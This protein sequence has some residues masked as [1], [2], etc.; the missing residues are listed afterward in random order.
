MRRYVPESPRWLITHARAEEARKQMGEIETQ[1]EQNE[2]RSS[3]APEGQPLTVRPRE[4]FGLGPIL[5]AMFGKFRARSF[6]ALALMT[7]QAFLFNSVFFTYGLVLERFYHV[8]AAHAGAFILPLALCNLLGPIILGPLFDSV[9]RKK[10]ISA[11]YLTSGVLLAA[12]AALFGMSV[13]GPWGQT[14]AWM[15]IFFVASA[16][17]SSAYMT[18]SEIFPLETRSLAIA[19]FYAAGTAVGGIA[20]PTLFGALIGGG[21]PW[22]VAGGYFAAAALMI[23]AGIVEI[24]WGIDAESKSLESVADPISS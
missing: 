11:T 9:G 4:H 8:P 13:F 12:V 5:S 20:G 15:A 1:V 14:F 3:P 22:A 16:S 10:M 24:F 7:A 2:G 17:A 23:G 19:V 21:A 6:L 18:A